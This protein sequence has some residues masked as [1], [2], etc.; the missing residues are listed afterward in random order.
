MRCYPPVIAPCTRVSGSGAKEMEIKRLKHINETMKIRR[1]L[2]MKTS[3][4]TG[5]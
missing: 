2:T 4:S 3:E 1:T 5:K